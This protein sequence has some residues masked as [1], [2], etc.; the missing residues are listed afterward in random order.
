M[1]QT[2]NTPLNS[3]LYEGNIHVRVLRNNKV[4][5]EKTFQNNGRWPLF[6]HL[7][8]ALAGQ[9][10]EAEKNR[11]LVIGIYT[12]DYNETPDANGAIPEINDSGTDANKI[13]TYAKFKN[14]RSGSPGMFMTAPEVKVTENEGI[15]T[16]TIT[17]DFLVPFNS[18]IFTDSGGWKTA[19][20]EDQRYKIDP[21]CLV[22]LYSKSNYW[23]A[24]RDLDETETYGNPSA[25]F[26]V[27]NEKHS[28]LLGSLLPMDMSVSSNEYSLEIKWVLTFDNK[29]KSNSNN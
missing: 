3:I 13:S 19:T 12:I 18:L 11:P 27:P 23:N 2:L 8:S 5:R 21:L 15:G 9:Y 1:K 7:V 26:F 16:A 4:I 29:P 20:S 6:S 14:I 28:T 25:F 10:S 22:C 17:Y 24:N